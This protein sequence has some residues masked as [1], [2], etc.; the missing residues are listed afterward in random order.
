M[1]S[2]ISVVIANLVM[3]VIESKAI[4]SFLHPP[5]VYGRYV[6]DTI[7]VLKKDP[8]DAFHAHL[9]DQERN[10]KF[11]VERA[12]RLLSGNIHQDQER[13]HI[14]KALSSNGYP[15]QFIRK[16]SRSNEKRNQ[17]QKKDPVGFAVF[18]H[19]YME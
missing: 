1:G 15:K 16:H 4:H 18:N 8:I 14:G 17:S 12:D 11:T 3:E 9:N 5:R 2:P 13:I 6:D 10:I 19:M 7:C